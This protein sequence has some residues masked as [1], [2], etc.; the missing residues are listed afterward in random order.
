MKI[1]DKL[2][3]LLLSTML[4]MGF[5]GCSDDDDIPSSDGE[6]APEFVVGQESIKVKIGPENKVTMNVEQGGGEYSAFILDEN[7][8]KAE[9]V[10]GAIRVEGF[11]NGQTSLII[12]DKYSRYRR[13]P[14]SVYTTDVLQ[15]STEKLDLKFPLG[16][17]GMQSANVV[18]GNGEYVITSDNPAVKVSIDAEGVISMTATSKKETYTANITVT[19]CTN[20]SANIAVT[21][22]ATMDPYTEKELDAIKE[23]SERVY[24]LNGSED[25]NQS[26]ADFV[27][28]VLEDGKLR[29]GWIYENW[30]T[31]YGKYYIDFEGD[32]SVG[33][34]KNALFSYYNMW[35]NYYGLKDYENQP[36][37]LEII[38]ND[39]TNIWGVFSFVDEE[40]EKLIFGHFCDTVEKE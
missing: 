16:H 11:A 21:V 28:E 25:S 29:Y 8:A 38:K 4:P 33:V 18:L 37:T 40:D 10:D 12:S 35:S 1:S 34:K 36:I 23:N 26:Y 13:V 7:I 15:L 24:S 30:G 17:S 14:V 32:K 2:I 3:I 39:G 31:L 22:V 5:V 19:D 27:N 20:L 9:M 6:E